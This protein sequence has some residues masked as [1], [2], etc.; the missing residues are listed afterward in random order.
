MAATSTVDGAMSWFTAELPT[1][2][3]MIAQAAAHGYDAHAWQLTWA[4]TVFLRRTGRRGERVRLHRIGLAAAERAGTPLV[5]AV[6][7]RLLADGL[8][9]LGEVEEAHELL[10]TSLE[11]CRALGDARGVFQAHLSLVRLW[12]AR[13]GRHEALRHAEAALAL[14]AGMGDLLARADGLNA[15]ARQ[16]LRLGL[17]ERSR[18]HAKRAL[19]LY[20]RLAF[21]EGEADALRTLGRVELRLGRPRDAIGCL[22]RAREL[23]QRLDD[24]FWEAHVLADL[25]DAYELVGETGRSRVSR[26]EAAEAFERLRLPVAE[27]ARAAR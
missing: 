8:T 9:R 18:V 12:E 10:E 21:T 17:D 1:L 16:Q 19:A 2:R 11:E 24:R 5:R 15:L 13:G 25:A 3:A 6:G 4:V 23:N 27:A 20:E 7:K 26:A 22:L 14:T